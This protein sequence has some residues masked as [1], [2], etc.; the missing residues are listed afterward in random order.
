MNG[1]V[2]DSSHETWIRVGIFVTCNLICGLV[3]N[4]LLPTQVKHK[5]LVKINFST[6]CNADP[7]TVTS[8]ARLAYCSVTV[9]L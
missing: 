7:L 3:R 1:T 9:S 6:T 5:Y 8:A 2:K 4:D